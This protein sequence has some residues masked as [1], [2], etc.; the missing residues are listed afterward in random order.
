MAQILFEGLTFNDVL[1]IPQV[2]LRDG[3][4]VFLDDITLEAFAEAVGFPVRAVE[5]DGA[6]L[7]MAL[8]GLA[9][10]EGM[11]R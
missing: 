2:C 10:C 3:E 1:L 7:L 5:N 9:D 4:D 6:A 8:T 11:E